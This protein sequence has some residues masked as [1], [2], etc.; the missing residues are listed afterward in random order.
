MKFLENIVNRILIHWQ[1]SLFGL[2]YAVIFYMM[3]S[4]NI[5]T[6]EG[7]ELMAGILA[8][9]GIFLNKDPDKTLTKPEIKEKQINIDKNTP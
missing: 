9:K 5:T 4:K 1:S 7:L 6:K 2:S 8:F 3:Y